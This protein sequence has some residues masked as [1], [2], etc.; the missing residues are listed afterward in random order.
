MNTDGQT[1]EVIM[2]NGVITRCMGKEYLH[3][4]MEGSMKVST[5]KIRSRV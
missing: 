4:Q 1:E 3:G 5:L 2:E